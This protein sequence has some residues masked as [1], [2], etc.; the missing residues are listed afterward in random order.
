MSGIAD[1]IAR[2]AR[3]ARNRLAMQ[4]LVA[5]GLRMRALD[6]LGVASIGAR[7]LVGRSVRLT[8]YGELTIGEEAILD[9]GCLLYVS[10]GARLVLG[11]RVR[12]GRNT[13]IAAANSI[14]IGSDV[15]IAEHCTIRDSDHQMDPDERRHETAVLTAPVRIGSNAWVGAGVR[16]LRGA[17]LGDAAVV[18]ANAV[19]R[20][21]IPARSV[22]VG[23][24]AREIKHLA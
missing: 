2:G 24:P 10:P 5:R 8:I 6:L 1:F 18:G 14:E 23:A 21:T 3:G 13:V 17:E 7:P 20:G 12:V 11:D 4:A 15:L 16:I 19:V 22:A 9:D